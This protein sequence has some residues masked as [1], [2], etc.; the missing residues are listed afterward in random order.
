MAALTFDGATFD[1]RRDGKRL[2]AQL[3][4]VRNFMVSHADEWWT[5]DEL[6]VALGHP[7]AS[8]SA[9]LRDLRKKRFGGFEIARKYVARGQWAYRLAGRLA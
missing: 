3:D 7:Q 1:Q 5:L 6:E 2:N 4:D 9:R 8:V